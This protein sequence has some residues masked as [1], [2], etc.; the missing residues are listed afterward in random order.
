MLDGKAS[1]VQVSLELILLSKGA[2]VRLSIV[3]SS[4]KN[5]MVFQIWSPSW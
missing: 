1:V 2:S 3:R 5:T 4:M